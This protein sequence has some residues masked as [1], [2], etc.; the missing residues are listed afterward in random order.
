MNASCRAQPWMHVFSGEAG[1]KYMEPEAGL[2]KTFPNFTAQR[3]KKLDSFPRFDN[4]LKYLHIINN[5]CES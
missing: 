4:N 3:G 1:L 5:C 2:W